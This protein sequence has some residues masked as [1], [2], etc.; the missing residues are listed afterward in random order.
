MSSLI[1]NY[2]GLMI[3]Y[4]NELEKLEQLEQNTNYEF[5]LWGKLLKSKDPLEQ[6]YDS[7][8]YKGLY[9]KTNTPKGIKEIIE[10]GMTTLKDQIEI[11]YISILDGAIPDFTKA[12]Y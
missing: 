7:I 1:T 2:K 6:K 5:V 9:N 4:I 11:K 3:I 10:Q 12:I 8:L